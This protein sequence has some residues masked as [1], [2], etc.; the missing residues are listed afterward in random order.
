[1]ARKFFVT[2][3]ARDQSVFSK[4]QRYDFDIFRPTSKVNERNE[5]TIEG[6]LAMDEVEK[7]VE[8]GFRVL[9]EEESSKRARVRSGGI[10]FEEW[11]KGMEEQ[12]DAAE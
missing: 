11:L 2:V 4:L 6:L 9:V 8:D 5:I 12:S 7:L 10:G 3:I 1:M